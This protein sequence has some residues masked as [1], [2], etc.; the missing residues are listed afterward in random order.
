MKQYILILLLFAM[1]CQTPNP[2]IE[3]SQ[4]TSIEM[5]PPP[6]KNLELT[7]HVYLSTTINDSIQ[8]VFLFDTGANELIVDQRFAKATQLEFISKEDLKKE[9]KYSY[10][11]GEGRL[12]N[13]Y[14]KQLIVK[15]ADRKFERQVVRTIAL[16]SL[17]GSVLNHEING[18]IGYDLF[19]DY[20]AFFDFDNYKLSLNDTIAPNLLK[21][22]E[23]IPFKKE[24]R[25]P[26]IQVELELP[27][28]KKIKSKLMFDMGSGRSVSLTHQKAISENLFNS[29]DSLNCYEEDVTGIGG[30]GK[31]C[32]GKIKS[33]R[34]GSSIQLDSI[35]IELGKDQKGALGMHTMYDGLLGMDIISRFN[36]IIDQKEKNIYL[37]KR[38]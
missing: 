34:F 3:E 7:S 26:M 6:P 5:P 20:W 28:D 12:Q 29:I 31:S 23:K 18:I 21:D 33:I 35:N 14:L 9:K 16:D 11:V 25:K 38:K 8:G 4:A 17:L 27:N 19:K 22:Y 2:E 30:Q 10:G 32:E 15:I 13:N 37:K 36:V 1:A 24:Y